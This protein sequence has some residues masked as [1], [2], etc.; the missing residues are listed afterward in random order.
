MLAEAAAAQFTSKSK[1]KNKGT[2]ER[3]RKDFSR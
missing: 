3:F 1:T 2:K